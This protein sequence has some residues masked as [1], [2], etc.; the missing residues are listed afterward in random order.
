MRVAAAR[1]TKAIALATIREHADDEDGGGDGGG[2]YRTTTR[3]IQA[4]ISSA[5]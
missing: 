4:L 3:M 5:K 2:L 1:M